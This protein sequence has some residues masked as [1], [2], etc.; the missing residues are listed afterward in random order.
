MCPLAQTDGHDAL[1]LV[2][3]L[4]PCEAAV[5]DDVIVG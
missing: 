1:G 4:V 5:I 2:D 3:D